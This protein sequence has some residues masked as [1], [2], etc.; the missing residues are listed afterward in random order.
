[1]I[2]YHRRDGYRCPVSRC[3]F[4]SLMGT[5]HFKKKGWPLPSKADQLKDLSHHMLEE[6][7]IS[8]TQKLLEACLIE[9]KE[10]TEDD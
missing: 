4:Y 6:H 7:P 9:L 8:E 2:D 10:L 1:M 5:G 3:Y